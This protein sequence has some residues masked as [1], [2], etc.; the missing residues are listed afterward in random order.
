[1]TRVEGVETS[2]RD[3]ARRQIAGLEKRLLV[4][5]LLQRDLE[6]LESVVLRLEDGDDAASQY[7]SMARK[8]VVALPALVS[9]VECRYLVGRLEAFLELERLVDR[10]QVIVHL[11]AVLEFV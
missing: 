5:A 2:R 10:L 9:S 7:R 3:L 6:V 4:H 11:V 8:L 1:M